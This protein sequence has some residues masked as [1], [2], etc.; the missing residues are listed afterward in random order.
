M[1]EGDEMLNSH[2]R[3]H[4]PEYAEIMERNP[5]ESGLVKEGRGKI[6]NRCIFL[7]YVH[8]YLSLAFC[9]CCSLIPELT[10]GGAS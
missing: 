6:R 7:P 8:L 1:V 10:V 9:L 5:P 2:G 4:P 3:V